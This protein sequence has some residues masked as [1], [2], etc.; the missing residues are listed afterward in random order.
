MAE[1]LRDLQTTG[2]NL[3]SATKV[4]AGREEASQDSIER[5]TGAVNSLSSQIGS[6][7]QQQ[8]GINAKLGIKILADIERPRPQAPHV[9]AS[10]SNSTNSEPPLSPDAKERKKVLAKMKDWVEGLTTTAKILGLV[11]V[12]IAVLLGAIYAVWKAWAWLHG[13]PPPPNFPIPLAK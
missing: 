7:I 11:P 3:V 1:A 8:E 10:E 5:L 13:G 4:L 2:Q 9:I 12:L 6:V